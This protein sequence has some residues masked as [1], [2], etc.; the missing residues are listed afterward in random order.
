MS[1]PILRGTMTSAAFSSKDINILSE[2]IQIKIDRDFK[3]AKFIVEYTIQSDVSG[4]QIPLLF[5]AKDY[6]DSFAVWVDNQRVVIQDIPAKYTQIDSPF[7]G[8]SNSFEL[9]KQPDAAYEVSISWTK[10]SSSVY[11][12]NNLKYFETDIAKG[13]HKVRVAYTA[14]VWTNNSGW[15]K[16]YSF[17]YSLTPAKFW[18]SFGTL[19]VNVEQEGS[20]RQLSTNIGLPIEQSFKA[21][22]TWTFNK[23]P[24]EYLAL[25]YT[26]KNTKF[27]RTLI[28]IEP[29]GL[30]LIAAVILFGL[31]LFL[32][33]W[34]R[35]RH[36]NT[37]YS[38]VVILGS[39]IVPLL[40][41]LSYLYSYGLID[42]V[43]GE[44]A[45]RHHGYT[46]LVII[47]Y[48]I[49]LPIYWAIFWLIDR[50]QKRR[51]I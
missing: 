19:N 7:S 41:L 17:R 34:Y 31:H 20:V 37:K 10:N 36:K 28:D 45:G 25:S 50:L 6:K 47:F 23:L 29:F 16:E 15:I 51:L 2:T 33:L 5:Y 8:F 46:F 32:V 3:T 12:L 21:I 30:A 40:I 44:D 42:N 48:P 38:P 43:I 9:N 49:I 13:I 26:P 27:T 22:N 24:A 18:K 14:S 35:R 11:Q 1:S 4:R 39:L